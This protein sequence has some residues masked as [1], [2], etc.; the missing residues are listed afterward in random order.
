MSPDRLDLVER[1]VQSHARTITELTKALAE[2]DKK[3]AVRDL[4]DE[5]LDEHLESIGARIDGI[6]RLGWW[7]LA[8]F[9]T[10]AVG[11]MANFIFRGGFVVGG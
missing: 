6:Y 9:G 5:H 7:I 1:D 11:L 8:A 4:R 2:V 3:E 10:S